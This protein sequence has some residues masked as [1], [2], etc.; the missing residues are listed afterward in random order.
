[1]QQGVSNRQR[2]NPR[3]AVRYSPRIQKQRFIK[4][5][6]ITGNVIEDEADDMVANTPRSGKCTS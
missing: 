3:D 1:V 2:A 4:I 5:A 6:L